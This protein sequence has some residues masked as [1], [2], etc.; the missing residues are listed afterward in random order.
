M[1]DDGTASTGWDTFLEAVIRAGFAITGTWPMRTELGNRQ[2]AW[3]QRSRLLHRPRLP[4]ARRP[5]RHRHAPR[6]RRRAQDRVAR[7]PRPPA[8]QQH[9]AGGPGSG[10]HR[11]R[12]GRLHPLRAGAGRRGQADDGAR[13]AGAHQPGPRRGAGRAGGRLRRR[14]PLGAGMVRAVG[15][16]EG[17]YGVAETLSKAKNTSVAGMVEAG[18]VASKA[19]KV[20]LLKPDELPADWDPTTDA[21]LTAWEM[22][23]HLIRVLEAGGEGAAAELVTKLAPR[24]RSRANWP[25]ASTRSASGRSG[26]RKPWPTT[27]SSRAGPRSPGWPAGAARRAAPRGDVR[28]RR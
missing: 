11:P 13:G 26:R 2:T 17:E 28:G 19:G 4:P 14:Q 6:V 15:F 23:H 25:I 1:S 12:H 5:T 16:A 20:R 3:D 21:R 24:P 18:I 10:R 7:G 22:V 9:R 27:R 8:A